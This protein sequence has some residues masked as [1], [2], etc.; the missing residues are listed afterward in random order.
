ML[1]CADKE[2]EKERICGTHLCGTIRRWRTKRGKSEKEGRR[3]GGTEDGT[4]GERCGEKMER[5]ELERERRKMSEKGGKR[6]HRGGEVGR[7]GGLVS[8][9]K[10]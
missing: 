2:R 5:R 8:I 7:R 6:K 9:R 4:E 10:Q 1:L 3:V